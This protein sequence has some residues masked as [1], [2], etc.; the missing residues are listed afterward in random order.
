MSMTRRTAAAAVASFLGGN[1]LSPLARAQASYP[2]KPI[3]LIVP[4]AAGGGSDFFARVVS[5]PLGEALGQ[6]VL[7]ENRPGASGMIAT[8]AVARSLPADGYSMLLTNK[9]LV[10]INQHMYAKTPYDVSELEPV[11]M[12]GRF[13]FVLVVNEKVLPATTVSDIFAASHKTPNGLNYGS[14][15]VGTTHDFAMELFSR[16]AGAKLTKVAY[17]GGAPAVQDLLAGHISLMFLDRA[18]ARPHI[19]AG[20]LRAIA[21]A[22]EKRVPS[23]PHLPTVAESGLS[24]FAIDDWL[25][26]TVRRGTPQEAVQKLASAFAK[27]AA[28][29]EIRKKLGD[30]GIQLESSSPAE[31]GRFIAKESADSK[32]LITKL[33]IR[34]E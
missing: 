27:V 30:S 3:K 2:N 12:G 32:D 9:A 10:C 21:V 22:G 17:K 6:T 15:G 8:S 29:A 20:K 28:M 25:G 7:V 13:D 4:Y 26:F 31:F 18:T 19:D 16:A 33:N 34:L 14:P 24:G 5:E 1:M 23:W 11:S